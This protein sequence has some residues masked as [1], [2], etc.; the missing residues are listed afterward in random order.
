M[1][2]VIAT[3]QRWPDAH[4]DSAESGKDSGESWLH[5][6]A[7]ALRKSL[8]EQRPWEDEVL[9]GVY[10]TRDAY[11]S[12]HGYDLDRIFA[13]LIRREASSRLGA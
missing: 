11:A 6:N 13:D 4:S 5:E 8:C 2:A 7:S 10:A 12:E 1:E 9:R 3:N